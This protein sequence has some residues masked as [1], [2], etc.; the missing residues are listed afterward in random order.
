MRAVDT[1]GTTKL[2]PTKLLAIPPVV[3]LELGL[4]LENYE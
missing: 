4:S 1:A 2:N 3:I